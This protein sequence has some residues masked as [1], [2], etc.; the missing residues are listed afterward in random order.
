[1]I[2]MSQIDILDA[3]MEAELNISYRLFSQINGNNF[4][5]CSTGENK[6]KIYLNTGLEMLCYK[7]LHENDPSLTIYESK[8]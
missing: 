2:R 7:V 6:G 4:S 8:I 1:M 3:V 5:I